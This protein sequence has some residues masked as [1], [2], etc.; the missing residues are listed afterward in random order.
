LPRALSPDATAALS[1]YL[2]AAVER[3]DVLGVVALVVGS[4]GVLYEKAAGHQDLAAAIP[5]S[6]G[7]LF[8]IA[9][10]TKPVTSVAVMMLH[11][12]GRFDLDDPIARYLPAFAD[13]QV[14]TDVESI[15]STV[16]ASSASRS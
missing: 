11:E 7:T 9:S 6:S 10:M 16:N 4:D 3:G 14:V 1:A 5:M 13:A 2:D 15:E 8:R 12:E